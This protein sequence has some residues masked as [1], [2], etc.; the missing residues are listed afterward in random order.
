M[1]RSSTGENVRFVEKCQAGLGIV[2]PNTLVTFQRAEGSSIN[3]VGKSL[4]K[5]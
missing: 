4:A 2:Y 1:I 3:L 5:E